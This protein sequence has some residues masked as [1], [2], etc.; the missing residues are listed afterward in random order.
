VRELIR[1]ILREENDKLQQ[2]HPMIN[3]IKH[4]VGNE[5]E[6]DFE[7]CVMDY[8]MPF[9]FNHDNFNGWLF[10]FA[11]RFDDSLNYLV[12]YLQDME[13]SDL[14]NMLHEAIPPNR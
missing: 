8:M 13:R 12:H 1:K 4:V 11:Y 5:Y 10:D 7:C 2:N 9:V 6:G 14:I 3:A